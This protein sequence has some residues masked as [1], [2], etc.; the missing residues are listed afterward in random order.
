[1]NPII[2]MTEMLLE[3]PLTAEQRDMI[4]TIRSSGRSLLGIINDVLDFS[5]IEAGKLVLEKIDFNLVALTEDAAELIA[6]RA[7]DKGL[8]MMTYIDPA[9]PA[10]LCGDPGRLRQV[11]L[12][13][14]GN[15]VKFTETG[16]VVIRVRLDDKNEGQPR[17]WFEI[18]DSGIGLSPEDKSRLFQPFTQADGSTSRKYGGTGL[19]LFN[20]QT[21]GGTDGWRNRRR[22]HKR[23]RGNLLFRLTAAA[24]VRGTG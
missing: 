7:R 9:I 24:V 16:E 11:L 4:R 20:F 12:N 10:T 1:M 22:K 19:G 21:A 13:L 2:G 8:A 15:A 23:R 5:K 17:L 3:T 14:A 18:K 6:W